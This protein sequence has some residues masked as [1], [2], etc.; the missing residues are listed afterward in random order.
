MILKL[1]VYIYNIHDKKSELIW[2]KIYCWQSDRL[3]DSIHTYIISCMT[4][5]HMTKTKINCQNVIPWLKIEPWDALGP[6][7]LRTMWH[8][9]GRQQQ[10]AARGVSARWIQLRCH[11]RLANVS[12]HFAASWQGFL[13]RMKPGMF[14][15]AGT[16]PKNKSCCWD[17]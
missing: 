3:S 10:S 17:Y 13:Q 2:N 6:W 7:E 15:H 12:C 11:I 5:D 9:H 16:H 14:W 4:Y 8:Q 1:T